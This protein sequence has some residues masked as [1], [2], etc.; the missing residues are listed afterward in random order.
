MTGESDSY[1]EGLF[2]DRKLWIRQLLDESRMHR[3]YCSCS[4]VMG[5]SAEPPPDSDGPTP[6]HKHTSSWAV[7][8]KNGKDDTSRPVI[9]K[10]KDGTWGPRG[11]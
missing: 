3:Y 11:F 1:V 4:K 9:A 5:E 10:K 6:H 2:R 8:I 7:P